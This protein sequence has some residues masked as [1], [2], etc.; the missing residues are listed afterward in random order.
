MKLIKINIYDYKIIEEDSVQFTVQNK[1]WF[2]SSI[3]KSNQYIILIGK[4]GNGKTSLCSFIANIFH[5]LDRDHQ[6]IRYKFLLEYEISNGRN[7]SIRRELTSK[8]I[9]IS[10]DHNTYKKIIPIPIPSKKNNQKSDDK[11]VLFEDIK[12]YIPSKVILST[13][14]MNGEYPFQRRSN[15]TGNK[16]LQIFNVS[17]VYGTNSF[18]YGSITKGIYKIIQNKEV[19]ESFRKVYKILGLE[20]KDKV[21]IKIVLSSFY[22]QPKKLEK[23]EKIL[24]KLSD[25]E[26]T[27]DD[28]EN[29][30]WIPT[31]E[32]LR[33]CVRYPNF[34]DDGIYLNNMLFSKNKK[35]LNF[36]LMSSGEKL[37]TFRLLGIL[38]EIEKDS[39]VIIEE[40]EL[41]LNDNWIELIVPFLSTLFSNMKSTFLITSHHTSIC[42]YFPSESILI[43]KQGKFKSPT[44]NSFMIDDINTITKDENFRYSEKWFESMMKTLNSNEQKEV[45]DNMDSSIIKV[46]HLIKEDYAKNN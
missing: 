25:E 30:F 8:P 27:S 24:E 43:A 45:L 21:N 28:V 9:E 19:L 33:I 41:H 4:N 7:I 6:K 32:A 23:L 29:S 39:L 36:Q 15:Y 46:K 40:P 31:S 1:K 17:D 12:N 14:S 16:T 34:I 44:L 5:N 13:F 11:Q 26:P 22:Q 18:A 35:E 37:L 38:N 10:I 2:E 42:N 20:L 3:A